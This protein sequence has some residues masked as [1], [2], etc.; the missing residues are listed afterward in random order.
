[1]Q[2]FPSVSVLTLREISAAASNEQNYNFGGF[3]SFLF[4]KGLHLTTLK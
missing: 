4:K 1:M 3:P 2:D